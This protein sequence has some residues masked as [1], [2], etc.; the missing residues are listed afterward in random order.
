MI[1][2][3][4][5]RI[6]LHAVLLLVLFAGVFV[7]TLLLAYRDGEEMPSSA[8]EG[9]QG[10]PG[11][12][13]RPV[14]GVVPDGVSAPVPRPD[15]PVA[16]SGWTRQ[17]GREMEYGIT[18]DAAMITKAVRGGPAQRDLRDA[19]LGLDFLDH[20]SRLDEDV[21]TQ[22]IQQATGVDSG[23]AMRLRE[24]AQSSR[25]ELAAKD[26]QGRA[27]F[28]TGRAGLRSQSQFQQAFDQMAAER[29][30]LRIGRYRGAEDVLGSSGMQRLQGYIAREYEAQTPV[31][32][33]EAGVRQGPDPDDSTVQKRLDQMCPEWD[34]SGRLR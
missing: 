2:A 4:M 29:Q 18:T 11:N 12:S 10:E 21:A 34:E 1:M 17:P 19:L 15:L 26:P 31:F 14:A 27:T 28:C 25:E 9:G 16:D 22:L 8:T 13:P 7:A 32:V 33:I 5:K 30:A 6:K 23:T 24:Y 3:A 20:V